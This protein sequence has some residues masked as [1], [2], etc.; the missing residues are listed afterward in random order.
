M[1]SLANEIEQIELLLDAGDERS[2][3]YAALEARLALEKLC[4]DRL[5]QKHDYIAH[6]D[7]RRW[8]PAKVMNQLL[9]EV[10][11]HSIHTRVLKISKQPHQ[12]GVTP[13]EED[14]VE[15]GT[16][17]GFDPSTVS[18]LWNALSNLALHARMPKN[19]G[20]PI[21]AYGAKSKIAA[22]VRETV[23]ELKRINGS[24]MTFS[25]IGE[26][27]RFDC[28]C[29]QKNK[30][31]AGLLREGQTISC[32][33]A[34]CTWSWIVHVEKDG[35]QFERQT[36]PVICKDCSH[37]EFL[38][39]REAERLPY[40]QVASWECSACKSTNLIRWRLCQATNK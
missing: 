26:E 23:A 25:G 32:A 9:E 24:T 16:E 8:Q 31:R 36:V 40:H 19:S 11:A 5:R 27:V 3:T 21:P 20:D 2:V 15:I 7:L 14:F 39:W 29:G 4:Y 13:S 22:K 28:D 35:I 17:V 6:S 33:N 30:R 18:K 34:E 10:D 38:P 37:E 12:E 1:I